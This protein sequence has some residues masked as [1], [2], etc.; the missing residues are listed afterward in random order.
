MCVSSHYLAGV[1]NVGN[2]SFDGATKPSEINQYIRPLGSLPLDRFGASI[3]APRYED[4]RQDCVQHLFPMPNR[5]HPSSMPTI[6]LDRYKKQRR[7]AGAENGTINREL[8]TLSHF[9]NRAV[10]WIA[11]KPTRI[12]KLG[13]SGGR[14]VALN[15]E[16]CDALLAAAVADTDPYCWLFV[17][18]GLNTAMR[19]SEILQARFE[20][21][22]FDHLRLYV[23][24]RRP[25]SANSQSRRNWPKR[26][27]KSARPPTMRTAG[28][29]RRRAQAR[30]RAGTGT[31]WISHSGARWSPPVSIRAASRPT[32]CAI[33]PSLSL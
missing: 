2:L 3:H 17:I 24:R 26:F 28:F 4:C 9:L 29:S 8:A 32:P 14:T 19:H 31:G 22:D 16:Q 30:P 21:V 23:P 27:G 18:F 12:S 1:L 10:D 25:D 7:D 33:R 15:D 11:A 5:H 6:D 13:E 20:N